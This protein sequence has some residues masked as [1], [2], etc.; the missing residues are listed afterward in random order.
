VLL[1]IDQADH[2]KETGTLGD[3]VDW[4]MGLR[5]DMAR[6]VK[7]RGALDLQPQSAKPSDL[8]D[9]NVAMV[10][11]RLDPGWDEA[12]IGTGQDFRLDHQFDEGSECRA[13][14]NVDRL[15]EILQR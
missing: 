3:S 15:V 13:F 2:V 1:Q 10:D 5:D 4:K 12:A 8:T 9:E 11:V 7:M 6:P 14:Q